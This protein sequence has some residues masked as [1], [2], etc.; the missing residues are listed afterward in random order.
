MLLSNSLV[1]CVHQLN[2]SFP[3]SGNIGTLTES[4]I[5]YIMK[6]FLSPPNLK[7]NTKWR[8][9]G[10]NNK[11]KLNSSTVTRNNNQ[12]GNTCHRLWDSASGRAEKQAALS[13]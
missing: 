5:D 10:M 11:D 7:Q 6:R 8:D 2:V 4:M 12:D 9:P 1:P 13:C 3:V